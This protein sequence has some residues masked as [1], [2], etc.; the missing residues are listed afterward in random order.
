MAWIARDGDAK[1]GLRNTIGGRLCMNSAAF[2]LQASFLRSWIAFTGRNTTHAKGQAPKIRIILLSYPHVPAPPPCSLIPFLSSTS[3]FLLRS[4][5]N[6]GL[7]TFSLAFCLPCSP[8]SIPAPPLGRLRP[9]TADVA[10]EFL[11]LGEEALSAGFRWRRVG[12]GKLFRLSTASTV[13]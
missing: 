4:C 3:T 2:F 10:P 9:S 7:M 5:L 12:V 8:S 6:S 11:A 13:R 1:G